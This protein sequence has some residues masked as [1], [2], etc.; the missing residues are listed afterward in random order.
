MY[1]KNLHYTLYLLILW[2]LSGA[3]Q[4]LM[5]DTIP[6][7]ST[8]MYEIEQRTF[9]KDKLHQ[10]QQDKR[11]SYDRPKPPSGLWEQFKSWLFQ[12]LAKNWPEASFGK[13][14]DY[15]LYIAIFIALILVIFS[16]LK[17][18]FTTL[19]FKPPKRNALPYDILTENIH[20]IDFDK[21]LQQAIDNKLYRKAIRLYYLQS[22][23]LLSDKL[24]I[25]WQ[26]N[27]TNQDY[28]KDLKN[29]ELQEPFKQISRLFEYVW[30]GNF[31]ITPIQFTQMGDKF[32]HFNRLITHSH[33]TV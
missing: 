18:D 14:W 26:I 21:L 23:K 28:Y 24:F 19:F 27:K 20:D 13:V 30:Y 7:A 4:L 32:T 10:Y 11:F 22:L 6:I 3:T 17:V 25:D 8:P 5:A 33:E 9:D 2:C 16:L 1:K 12:K 29:S 15:L 31:T